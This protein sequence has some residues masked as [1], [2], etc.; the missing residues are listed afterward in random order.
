MIFPESMA[1]ENKIKT[2]FWCKHVFFFIRNRCGG[3]EAEVPYF[4]KSLFEPH[5]SLIGSLF[6]SR[7]FYQIESSLVFL[8]FE[9]LVQPDG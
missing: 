1:A 6:L 9:L 2:L 8:R 7:L 5:S 4:F 3:V